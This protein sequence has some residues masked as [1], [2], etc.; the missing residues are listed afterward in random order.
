MHLEGIKMSIVV[1]GDGCKTK[2][3]SIAKDLDTGLIK[4]AVFSNAQSLPQQKLEPSFN[5]L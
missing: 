1:G 3:L 4:S 5:D 2:W